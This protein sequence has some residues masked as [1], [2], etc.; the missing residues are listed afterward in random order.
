MVIGAEPIS[1][2]FE[3][4]RLPGRAKIDRHMHCRNLAIAGPGMTTQLKRRVEEADLVGLSFDAQLPFDGQR[5][6][7]RDRGDALLSEGA[8]QPDPVPVGD[9]IAGASGAATDRIAS[10]KG[11]MTMRA[12]LDSRRGSNSIPSMAWDPM[13]RSASHH[14]SWLYW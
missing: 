4:G 13:V 5:G 14:P 2:L 10:W 7:G 11:G 1:G 6:P 8:P 12:R 9:L 3:T